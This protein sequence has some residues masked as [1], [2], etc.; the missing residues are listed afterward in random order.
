MPAPPAQLLAWDSEFF[1]RRIARVAARGLEAGQQGALWDWVRSEKIDCLYYLADAADTA[2]VRAAEDAGFRLVDVRVTRVLENPPPAPQAQGGIRA[3][4]AEDLPALRAIARV[5]HGDTRFFHDPKLPR[6]RCEALYETWIERACEGRADH[7]WV[8]EERGAV[9]GYLA[10]ALVPD[11]TGSIDLFA[12]APERRGG[13]I[14]ERLVRA[15]L[16]WFAGQ[17]CRQV[18]VVSQA[19]NLPA[20]RVYESTGFR[21]VSVELW[22]HLWP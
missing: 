17:G 18:R 4:R 22:Y 5:S 8:A 3:A 12:V 21:T 15:S 13:G 11:A 7:V 14:G 6:E 20:T 19:R 1:G 10:C 16:G 2:S 9:A